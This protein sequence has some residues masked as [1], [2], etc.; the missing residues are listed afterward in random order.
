MNKI[1]FLIPIYPPHFK[2]AENIIKTWEE[3]K[4]NTQSDI[5]FVFTNEEEKEKYIYV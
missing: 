3:N 1:T 2:Y 4:L 5:W